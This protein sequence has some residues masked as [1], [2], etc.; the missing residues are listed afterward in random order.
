MCGR[1]ARATELEAILRRLRF[2]TSE[3]TELHP[4]YNVA[5]GQAVAAVRAEDGRRLLVSLKWGLIPSWATDPKIA[6]S[7]INAR[8]ETVAE[9]PAFRAAFKARRRL[10]PATAFYEWQKVG[11]KH[12]QPYAFAVRD[13]E[14][15]AFA[16]LWERWRDN[17]DVESGVV[18]SCTILTTTANAVVQPVH[19]RMPVIIPPKDY[20]AWLDPR[21]P[22]ADLRDVLRPYPDAE[23]VG[24]AVS[25]Y[26]NNARNERPQCLTP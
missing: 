22:T 7:L 21:T 8:A 5:P 11:T 15:F 25:S 18:Q 10:I 23:M 4:R 19:N 26:V 16:G 6:F 13:G 12:K 20:D 1:F 3:L 9:K 14:M 17:D 24:R 2:D